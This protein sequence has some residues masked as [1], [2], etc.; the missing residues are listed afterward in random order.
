MS[1]K[2]DKLIRELRNRSIDMSVT[3]ETKKKSNASKELEN[4]IVVY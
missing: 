2:E 3:S 1:E 4:Y